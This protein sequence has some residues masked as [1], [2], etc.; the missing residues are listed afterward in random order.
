MISD[1]ICEIP[2]SNLVFQREMCYAFFTRN[3]FSAQTLNL[4]GDLSVRVYVH[5]DPDQVMHRMTI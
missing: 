3:G 4:P 2:I 1:I 5:T